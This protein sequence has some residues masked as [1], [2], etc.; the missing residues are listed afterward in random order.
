MSL[1]DEYSSV[2]ADSLSRRQPVT[3]YDRAVLGAI[4]FLIFF[5]PLAFGTVYP[6]ACTLMEA[7]SF[8]L[9]VALMV[10]LLTYRGD[11]PGSLLARL[12]VA[13]FALLIALLLVQAVR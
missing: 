8:L 9:G 6:R 7:A 1:H 4:L 13:A 11:A 3:V 2:G 10:R 12:P 5:T